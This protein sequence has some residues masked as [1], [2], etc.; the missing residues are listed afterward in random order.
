MEDTR[1]R[2]RTVRERIEQHAHDITMAALAIEDLT[3][4]AARGTPERRL[5]MAA[6]AAL[7]H[8]DAILKGGKDELQTKE[9]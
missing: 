6:R 1:T 2:E 7:F 3:L 9:D 8:A 4:G 5:K